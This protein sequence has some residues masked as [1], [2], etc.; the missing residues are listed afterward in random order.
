VK[1]FH[2]CA[3]GRNIRSVKNDQCC[4]CRGRNQERDSRLTPE[5]AAYHESRILAEQQR[6]QA[7]LS[8]LVEAGA[9]K[10]ATPAQRRKR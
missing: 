4:I 10:R 9:E 2:K 7:E 1:T 6:V 5:Q 8:R 3:C